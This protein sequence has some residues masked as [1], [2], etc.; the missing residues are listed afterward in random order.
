MSIGYAC[1]AV[2]VPQSEMKSLSLAKVT[3]TTLL[4][5]CRTNLS[6]LKNLLLYTQ[7][8]RISLFRISSDLIPFGSSEAN[9]INWREIFAEALLELGSL[10]TEGGIR[11]SMHP[12]QYTVL[13]S[14]RT[15][16]VEHA[17]ADLVYH[18]RVLSGMGLGNMHKI[19]LHIGGAYGDKAEATKRFVSTYRSLP[20]AVQDRL[21]IE[22]DDKLYTI[23]EVLAISD[24]VGCPVVF[25]NLHHAINASPGSLTE[26]QWIERCAS[27]W[28]A[29]DGKQKIHFA[30]QDPGKR[31][32]SHSPSIRLDDFLPF[33][34]TLAD[35]DIDIM[36]EVKDKNV[37]A[38]QCMHATSG[39]TREELQKQWTKYRPLV[40]ERDPAKVWKM[41]E[42]L[43]DAEPGQQASIAFYRL[44]QTYL[45]LEVSRS[46][47]SITA[48]TMAE[49]CIRTEAEEKRITERIDQY[50]MAAIPLTK[51]KQSIMNIA[52][53]H[54]VDEVLTSYY[55]LL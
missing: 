24:E 48:A 34:E 47:A 15:E 28:K 22:N 41:E 30:Q 52:N 8:N 35:K 20:Q 23:S 16:V 26:F 7:A 32:G 46:Q 14:P 37:S 51:L 33:Y 42:L 29:G 40:T 54:G 12:G 31:A 2:G 17:I 10:A 53:K 49:M 50:K 21:V 38:L 6:H 18:D 11:L 3:D 9:T 5:T 44:L 55:S 25:D 36:L 13:N 1:L 45:A 43:R 4:Q 39:A 27:T 19:V